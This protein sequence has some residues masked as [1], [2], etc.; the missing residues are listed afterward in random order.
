MTG[1]FKANNPSNNFG[2]LLYGLLLKLP[3]FLYPVIPP[4]QSSDAIIYRAFV[5]WSQ[6]VFV[7]APIFY[8]VL[9]FI[10][11]YIQA[12]SFNT[13]VN[14]QRML[15]RPNYLTGMS[16]LLITSLFAEW[17]SL[18]AALMVNTALI[19]V[20]SNLCSLHN[21]TSAKSTIYNIGLVIGLATFFYYPAITFSF[22]FMVGLAITRP[23]Q[24]KEWLIGLVGLA[25]AF[26]F[27]GA[28]LF[29]SGQWSSYVTPQ[30]VLSVP[31]FFETKWASA[32]IILVLI[33]MLFGIFF[34][35]SN[36]RRQIVQVRK[37][38]QLVYL[39]LIVAALVPFLNGSN[40][41]GSW[42]LVAVPASL[43]AASA[44]FYPDKKWFP[45][46]IHWAMVAISV[47]VAYFVR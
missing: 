39:Y 19:W 30:V 34:I 15:Q 8:S 4:V 33:T 31:V 14:S 21:N 5:A 18:S 16:Y 2:L 12:V 24:L 46:A 17:F 45:L 35:Q 20:W 3:L 27:F 28:W 44:L 43:I 13:V 9:A 23:F 25:T 36:M 26:Y 41:F 38:W 11:L 1:I 6:T 42:I 40:I 32:A 10:F 22:L 29:L 47:T 7:G 37:S